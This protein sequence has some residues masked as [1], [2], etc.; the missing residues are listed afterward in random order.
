MNKKTY[1]VETWKNRRMWG[2]KAVKEEKM[3]FVF[4]KVKRCSTTEIAIHC[5]M[6]M[7]ASVRRERDGRRDIMYKLEEVGN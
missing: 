2:K 3:G 4:C 6:C 1:C 7:A 5:L